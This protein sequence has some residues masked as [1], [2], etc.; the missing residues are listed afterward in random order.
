MAFFGYERR[1]HD[2][3]ITTLEELLGSTRLKTL[4]EEHRGRQ[5]DE[6]I[7]EAAEPTW[8]S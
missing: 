1:R 5:L 7:D 3:L 4:R 6:L 8:S 2:A